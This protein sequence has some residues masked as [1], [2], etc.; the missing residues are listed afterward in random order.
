MSSTT[1]YLEIY[2]AEISKLSR[3]FIINSAVYKL[4]KKTLLSLPNQ[5]Y[6]AI[7]HQ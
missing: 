3:K 5:K 2:D 6:K 7:T 1:S 4:E